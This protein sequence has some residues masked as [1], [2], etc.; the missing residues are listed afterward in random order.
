MRTPTVSMDYRL[1]VTCHNRHSGAGG[2][3]MGFRDHAAPRSKGQFGRGGR[4][5]E[6]C[7]P[8]VITSEPANRNHAQNMKWLPPTPVLAS[9]VQSPADASRLTRTSGRAHNA[10]CLSFLERFVFWFS[11]A[12]M[13]EAPT[14]A[15]ELLPPIHPRIPRTSR[16]LGPKRLQC[17]FGRFISNARQI[18]FMLDA[19]IF[20][21]R[22]GP[23]DV[24]K[25]CDP[26]GVLDYCAVVLF[27]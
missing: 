25:P 14:G 11:E 19:R 24:G 26:Y 1:R 4:A 22:N 17:K 5:G 15:G 20:F 16:I 12:P 23:S 2:T 10:S 27:L 8:R 7:H 21:L 6:R 13:G 9:S 3:G 18:G